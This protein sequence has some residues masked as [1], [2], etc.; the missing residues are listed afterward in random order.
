MTRIVLSALLVMLFAAP[1]SVSGASANE[2]GPRDIIPSCHNNT[3]L[4]RV[5]S[6][7]AY[8]NYQF[9]WGV[10]IGRITDVYEKPMAINA[11]DSLITRRY[12]GGTAWLSDGSH[13]EVYYLIESSQGFVSIG[14]SVQSCLP[15]FDPWRT[16]D[17][18][19]RAI[20]P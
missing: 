9:H 5:V 11:P 8:A 7:L 13:S 12:C 20:G 19:C 4:K 3:V 2:F 6:K 17:G 1:A 18:W 15:K 16:Y 14:Y 10:S